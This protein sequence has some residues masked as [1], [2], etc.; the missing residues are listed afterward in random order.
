MW[1]NWPLKLVAR[2]KPKICKG[3]GY[4]K[5]SRRIKISLKVEPLFLWVMREG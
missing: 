1:R 3:L 5:L 4:A 2:R